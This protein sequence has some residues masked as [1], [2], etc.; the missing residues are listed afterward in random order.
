MLQDR[1]PMCMERLIKSEHV[2]VSVHRD[3]I[4]IGGERSADLE[5]SGRILN[6]VT[7]WVRDGITIEANQRHVRN[8]FEGS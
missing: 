4:T 1:V 5:K 2:V 3:D 8:I 7:K 6:R